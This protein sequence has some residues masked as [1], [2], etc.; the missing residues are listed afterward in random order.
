MRLHPICLSLLVTLVSAPL[1]SA[2]VESPGDLVPD[3]PPTFDTPVLVH[4]G[5]WLESE[6]D[7]AWT[8]LEPGAYLLRLRRPTGAWI[9]ETWYYRLPSDPTR[10]FTHDELLAERAAGRVD[11]TEEPASVV[12]QVLVYARDEAQ[13]ARLGRAMRPGRAPARVVEAVRARA[14]I[15]LP[16][17]DEA[18]C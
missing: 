17:D 15:E 9:V 14:A 1:A 3:A 13:A 16:R 8:E 11:E 2:T 12:D 18:G 4:E 7:T 6:L 10:V 5:A